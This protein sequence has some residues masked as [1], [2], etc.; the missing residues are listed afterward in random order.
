MLNNDTD[1]FNFRRISRHDMD[2]KIIF[3]KK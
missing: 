3:K 1:F 2:D